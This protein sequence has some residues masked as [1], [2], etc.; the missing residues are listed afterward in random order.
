MRIR[1]VIS[2]SQNYNGLKDTYLYYS[3]NMFYQNFYATTEDNYVPLNSVPYYLFLKY[4]CENRQ[5]LEERILYKKPKLNKIPNVCLPNLKTFSNKVVYQ[6]ESDEFF[7]GVY[8]ITLKGC[9]TQLYPY[10][11]GILDSEFSNL[12]CFVVKGV[13]LKNLYEENYFGA[14]MD[15][16]KELDSKNLTLLVSSRFLEAPYKTAFHWLNRNFFKSLI[17]EF[18]INIIIIED[19]DNLIYNESNK[20]FAYQFTTLDEQE[21]YAKDLINGF[22]AQ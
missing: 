11:G 21:K 19:I 5:N 6:R 1:N 16:F 8:N 14:R 13:I 7:K 20:I 2:L 9:T 17:E 22:Y 12:I 18:D 15:N 10:F 4:T 3:Q